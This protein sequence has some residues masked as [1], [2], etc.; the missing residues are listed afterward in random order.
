MNTHDLFHR[1]P[2]GVLVSFI[3]S[4][5]VIIGTAF[6]Y[7]QYQ[8]NNIIALKQ[9]ELSAVADMKVTEIVNW[10]NERLGDGT[11]IARNPMI[12][13]HIQSFMQSP[14]DKN[15]QEMLQRWFDIMN[16][17]NLYSSI[18]LYDARGKMLYA[19]QPADQTCEML[20]AIVSEAISGK[21]VFLSDLHTIN[22]P[23]AIHM[24]LIIPI[25]QE[26][27]IGVNVIAVIA[28]RIDP[29]SYLYPL[30]NTQPYFS[31]TFETLIIRKEGDSV[32]F[33]SGLRHQAK[34]ALR[35]KVSLA[36]TMMPAVSAVNK[37]EGIYDGIDYRHVPVIS[38]VRKVS[39][40]SWYMIAKIDKDELFAPLQS[41][42]KIV[43]TV[44]LLLILISISVIGLIWRS[45]RAEHYRIL[46]ES[47]TKRRRLNEQLQEKTQYFQ[48]LFD[49]ANAPIIVWDEA[50]R[51]IQFNHAF[52]VLSGYNIEDVSEKQIDMLFPRDKIGSS[53]QLIG[54]TSAGERWNSVEIE[55]QNTDGDVRTLLWNSAN[56][57]DEQSHKII[58][59]IAQGHDITERKRALT[60]LQES[61]VKFRQTF[62]LSPVGIVMVGLDQKFIRC[63]NAFSELLG[64]TPDELIGKMI[65]EITYPDDVQIGIPDMI[66]LKN[67]EINS[68]RVKKR[69][70]HKNGQIVWGDVTISAIKDSADHPQYFL[71]II[72][73]ITELKI[74]GDLNS[75]R[76][77]LIEYAETHTVKEILQTTLDEASAL[78]SSPIGFYH[79]VD[80]DE[81]SLT[82]QAW[83]TR[84]RNE[85]CT[86][87]GEDSHYPLEKAG[88]WADCARER[89]PVIH[90][91]YAS[92]PN[93]HGLPQ[94][95]AG[96]VREAVVPI[97]RNNHV[98]AIIGVGNKMYDYTQTDVK[99]IKELGEMSWDIMGRKKIEEDLN[100][101]RM[102]LNAIF[103]SSPVG[104]LVLDEQTNIILAN[105]AILKL[106]GSTE[107]HVVHQRPG[108]ALQCFHNS[109]DPR[110]CGYGDHCKICPLRKGIETL[111]AKGGH[112][113]GVE[114]PL[115]LIRNEH[116]EE[117]WLSV[118][119]E[120]IVMYGRPH[121]VVSLD[122]ITDRK[123]AVRELFVSEKLL[124]ESQIIAGLGNYA[125][126]LR[127]GNWTSS[128]MLDTVFGIDTAYE[129]TMEGWK[130]IIHSDDRE[131]MDDYLNN[132]V[133]GQKKLFDKEYRFVRRYDGAVRWA[134]GL[135]VLELDPQGNI[136]NMH[137]TIQ[138]I[139]DRKRS[140][141]AITESE[142]RYR[143][144]L[145]NLDAAVVVHS[146]DTSIIL[147]NHRASELL[148]LSEDQMRGKR[149]IDPAW[150]FLDEHS[151]PLPLEKYPVN[152]IQTTLRPFSNWVLGIN[153]PATN[154]VVWVSVNG[155]PVFN[156]QQELTEIV[157]SFIDFTD[158]IKAEREIQQLN[159]TLEQRVRERTT[160]LE[161]ANKELESFS[162]S[163]SHDLRAPLR[164]IDG[165][166]QALLE[167]YNAMLD[168][169]GKQYL[170]R[171]RAGTQTMASLIDNMLDLSRVSRASIYAV[172]IN[173][174]SVVH[175]ILEELRSNDTNR[176]AE[177]I[178]T[179]G[180][181][182]TADPVLMRM[183]LQNLLEN[184]W[185]FTSKKPVTHIEF[186]ITA[187]DG[188]KTY[189]VRDN[190]AGFEMEYIGKLFTPF[191]R[192]HQTTEFP[193]TGIGLATVQRIIH[194]H[195]GTIW[196]KGKV[197]LGATF[198]FTLNAEKETL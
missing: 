36:D 185:K 168:E 88:V 23:D 35:L 30:L 40:S 48:N 56:I 120:P 180:L 188:T 181:T 10:R 25:L 143:S 162:Y 127:T 80:P 177:F 55:I 121:V 17:S 170:R 102:N 140:E 176:T 98:V 144:L 104:K 14:N 130:S 135:G 117:V 26:R 189:F 49:Y 52:Q 138:D 159:V 8:Q 192:L 84:T 146:P 156:Q 76:L 27:G 132:I 72:Q 11:M 12:T 1:F 28:A 124:R 187:K 45:Q 24:D 16:E 82:L 18:V 21:N 105:A 69:Y 154:D 60:A 122:D 148:G 111:I 178:I 87:A 33:L 39:R 71:A 145:N 182:D 62:D 196:A 123:K 157:I 109:A 22:G 99:V 42:I 64:Y 119:A 86:A 155:F 191:Q 107:S 164:S 137:G 161:V 153:R 194:R 134:H 13:H 174:S 57:V 169:Q 101:E 90:N 94:G 195:Y 77:R 68:S 190:G 152:Y 6:L 126:D 186:G 75:A 103:E 59:T 65:K 108:V 150:K 83:S 149:A 166:S 44:V 96:V 51:I 193:G 29:K 43:I 110:G 53:L 63:N 172:T 79:F 67:N 2:R 92:L 106:T 116:P 38:A 66:A 47:E 7:Y 142:N 74:S 173:L 19:K 136:L 9:N 32:L 61:E 129:R 97:I 113:R 198:Y 5:V 41:E 54:R 15:Q 133:S 58:A 20:P 165:F 95:H 128:A 141:L 31:K 50:L 115:T 151:N 112:L 167:D 171:V 184:A 73:D 70:L 160:L 37:G 114:L 91:D 81:H 93:K 139:T 175:S 163:V 147:S 78:V 85:F 179:P 46:Y 183:V 4:T 197:D 131:M 125:L 100:T 3:V 158:R 34:A 89:R 118:G